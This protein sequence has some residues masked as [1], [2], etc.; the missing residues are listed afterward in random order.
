MNA[1]RNYILVDDDPNNN[2][3][4]NIM[5]E[6]VLGKVNVTTF[7]V[8]EA[9]LSYIQNDFSK[10]LIPSILFLDINM[11]TLSGW[12][13][14]DEYKNFDEIIRNQ[15]SVYM[16]S[17]SVDQRDKERADANSIIKG[18]FTKPLEKDTILLIAGDYNYSNYCL[19][20]LHKFGN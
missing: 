1:V 11:P 9:A 17:S 2:I 20:Q 13:F 8:P 15:I 10:I 5:L 7:E 19:S 16:L 18:F 6:M 3:I 12:E 4:S 14:L